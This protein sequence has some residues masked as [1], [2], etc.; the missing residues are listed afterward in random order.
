MASLGWL[1][2]QTAAKNIGKV[3]LMPA[4]ATTAVV[5][6]FVVMGVILWSLN[7]DVLRFVLFE[8]G[9][10]AYDKFTFF[11]SVYKGIFSAF[12]N[13]QALSI[14]IFSVLFGINIAALSFVL[15]RQRSRKALTGSSVAGLGAAILGGGCIACGTS[16]LTPVLTSLG[17][18]GA[19]A[20]T[21]SLGI[22]LNVVGSVLIIWSLYRLG[23]LVGTILAKQAQ[24]S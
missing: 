17:V 9:I 13:L 23:L 2:I 12:G 4:Y 20:F 19:T 15:F 11:I 7:F 21:H 14:I 18:L 22:I 8:S 3:L 1:K 5:G 6:M 10:S 16:I 24:A